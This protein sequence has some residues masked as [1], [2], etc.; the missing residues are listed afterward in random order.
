M[1]DGLL[2]RVAAKRSKEMNG[3]GSKGERLKA[4]MTE[5]SGMC[6]VLTC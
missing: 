6:F 2:A 3:V 1:C 4:L 5:S